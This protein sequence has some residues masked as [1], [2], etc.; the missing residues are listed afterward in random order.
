MKMGNN[1]NMSCIVKFSDKRRVI[2]KIDTTCRK[3]YFKNI[4]I[5]RE[6]NKWKPRHGH[7]SGKVLKITKMWYIETTNIAFK[8]ENECAHIV[9]NLTRQVYFNFMYRKNV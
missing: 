6:S 3:I 1:M 7:R 2:S 8:L 4:V 5:N 9:Y